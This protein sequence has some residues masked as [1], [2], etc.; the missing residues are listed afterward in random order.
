MTTSTRPPVA[1]AAERRTVVGHAIERAARMPRSIPVLV[2]LALIWAVFYSQSPF[3]LSFG[4]LTN[5]TLQIV[6]T[7]ILSLGVVFVLLVGEIDLSSAAL[8]GVCAAVA[9]TVVVTHGLPLAVG[10]ATAVVLGM[11]VTFVEAQVIIFGVPSLIVTLG[12]MVILQGLLLVVLPEE[13][14]I[15]I[16]GTPLASLALTAVPAGASFALAAVGALAFAGYRTLLHRERTSTGSGG[17]VLRSVAAP[18][19]AAAV[20]LFAVVFVLSRQRGLP[21]PVLILAGMLLVAW[22]WTTQTRYGTH[23][24]AVGGDREAAQRAGIPVRRMVM[25]SFLVLG[26]CAA[27][28]GMVDSSRQRGVSATSGGGPLMLN[29]IAA[30]VGGGTSLF[31]GRGSVW[32]ALLGSLVIGSISN[33]VQLLGLSTEVQFF[34]TGVVL[35]LAVAVDVVLSRGSLLP[36]RR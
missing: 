31:G 28:A 18:S 32:S 21:L 27:V 33:G 2:T 29:A 17:S 5:L 8:S 15:S 19:V 11:V 14:T 26:A 20:G 9:G 35:V 1:P 30:A 13:F 10:I 24:Y 34:A 12:G 23:L 36:G 4:N 25:Y 6:T 7:A 16:A 3:Y 22:Y